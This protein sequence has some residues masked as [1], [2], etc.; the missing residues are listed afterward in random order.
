[1][2]SEMAVE[3]IEQMQADGLKPTVKDIIRL[4]ALALKYERA[5]S[6]NADN[7]LYLMPRV[8]AIDSKHV[9]RQPTIGHEIWFDKVSQIAD[10]G[11]QT[12]FALRAYAL[13]RDCDQ[14]CDPCDREKLVEEVKKFLDSVKHS[15]EDQIFAAL[16]YVQNG[17]YSDSGEYPAPAKANDDEDSEVEDWRECIAIG[18]LHEAQTILHGVSAAE[19]MKMTR[20][21][22][23]AVIHR[24]YAVQGLSG[25][26]PGSYE[27]GCYYRTL[28]DIR[29]RL[30]AEKKDD[31]KESE[32]K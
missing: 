2:T 22:L 30:E 17:L 28:D 20:P 16:N 3:D 31:C 12:T 7:S 11:Y 8:A 24:A 29:K 26:K 14:L 27:L 25:D 23:D 5:K 32:D 6:R 4:N 9:F 15:T 21:E 13:S 19:A 1:M 10:Y 18:T